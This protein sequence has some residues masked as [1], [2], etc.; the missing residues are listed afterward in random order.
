MLWH[1]LSE[2]LVE[3]HSSALRRDGQYDHWRIGAGLAR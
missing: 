1:E 3:P 2:R